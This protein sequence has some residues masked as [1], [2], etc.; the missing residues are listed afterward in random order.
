MSGLDGSMISRE[1]T[2]K[3]IECHGE[4]AVDGSPFLGPRTPSW[5]P[6]EGT[7]ASN[8]SNGPNEMAFTSTMG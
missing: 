1:E 7:I 2:S 6:Y 3:I 4:F 8:T 5:R